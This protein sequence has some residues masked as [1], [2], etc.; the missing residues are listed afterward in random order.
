MQNGSNYCRHLDICDTAY[1]SEEKVV[2]I[3]DYKHKYLECSLTAR[4]FTKAVGSLYEFY[5]HEF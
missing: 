4:S 1:T 5:R 3:Y 2:Q